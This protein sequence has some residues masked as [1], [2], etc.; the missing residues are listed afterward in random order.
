MPNLPLL[1]ESFLKQAAN[2]NIVSSW[3]VQGDGGEL[4]VEL[5]F[6]PIKGEATPKKKK[7]K[8]PSTKRHELRRLDTFLEKKREEKAPSPLR[9][10]ETFS[11][12][13][14]EKV[15]SAHQEDTVPEKFP[16]ETLLPLYAGFDPP[17]EPEE[18]TC[19]TKKR[20]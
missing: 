6:T 11:G 17:P 14:I 12:K 8:S 1:L 2:E 7:K 15:N 3:S 5:I 18:N 9:A 16:D 20:G 13:P 4:K 19:N 10:A